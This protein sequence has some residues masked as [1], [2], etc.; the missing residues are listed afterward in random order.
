MRLSQWRQVHKI[1]RSGYNPLL[2]QVIRGALQTLAEQPFCPGRSALN[3]LECVNFRFVSSPPVAHWHEALGH[4]TL[5][6]AILDRLVHDA[7]PLHLTGESLR[8]HRPPLTKEDTQ[9]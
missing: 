9:A 7:H 2:S 1:H 5:A 8:K 6:D 3:T 4:S